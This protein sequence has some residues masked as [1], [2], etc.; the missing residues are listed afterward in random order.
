VM[1]RSC[2]AREAVR[3]YYADF[4]NIQALPATV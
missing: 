4:L 3:L 2:A 1:W